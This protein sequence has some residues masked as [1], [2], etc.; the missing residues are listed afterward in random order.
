MDAPWLDAALAAIEFL[1]HPMPDSVKPETFHP[2][3]E[4]A[5]LGLP[6]PHAAPFARMLDHPAITRRLQ[7]ILGPGWVVEGP[8]A[9]TTASA[10]GAPL[11]IHSGG[12]PTTPI[13]LVRTKHGRS[14]CEVVK[15]AWQL[16]D[17]NLKGQR[18]GGYICIPGSHHARRQL[19]FGADFQR[20]DPMADVNLG[21]REDGHLQ[22]LSMR[23]GD[24]CI[25]MAASQ[26]HGAAGWRDVDGR[27][28][29][30]YGIWSRARARLR[31]AYAIGGNDNARL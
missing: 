4:G 28:A 7:W 3:P 20:E 18:D 2:L 19:P 12:A 25:F 31:Q 29:V 16:R 17:V 23:A 10:G 9:P 30:I 24:V 13:N 14:H 5:L 21:L 1:K 27:R 6:E 11:A 15:V 8:P 22:L 26:T